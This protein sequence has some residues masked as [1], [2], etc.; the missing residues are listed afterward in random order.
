MIL[1]RL[2]RRAIHA[3][4]HL[5]LASGL[6]WTVLRGGLGWKGIGDGFPRPLATISLEVHG[7]AAMGALFLLGSLTTRHVV[8]G[9]CSRTNR[10]SGVILIGVQ[11]TLVL[12]GYAL[13]YAGEASRDAA[14]VVHLIVG[15][16]CV[17]IIAWHATAAWRRRAAV[18]SRSVPGTITDLGCNPAEW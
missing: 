14:S 8:R 2:H 7:A 10:A 4:F 6:V 15:I 16:S 12:T 3:T 1:S 11:A 17:P 18:R 9:W 5:L 13:Y